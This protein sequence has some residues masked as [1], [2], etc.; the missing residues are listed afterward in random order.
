MEEIKEDVK[1]D[2][3][4]TALTY[5]SNNPQTIEEKKQLGRDNSAKIMYQAKSKFL[6]FHYSRHCGISSKIAFNKYL[7]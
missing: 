4:Q 3:K 2:K 6:V 1:D 5:L 7:F